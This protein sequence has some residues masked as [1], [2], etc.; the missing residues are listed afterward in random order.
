[1]TDVNA[2]KRI[3]V[4]LAKPAVLMEPARLESGSEPGFPA[5][6]LLGLY[7]VVP[8]WTM[9][10]PY[11]EAHVDDVLAELRMAHWSAL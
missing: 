9:W 4:V 5:G 8:P 7:H 3:R 1:M 10:K 6:S 11:L 2:G